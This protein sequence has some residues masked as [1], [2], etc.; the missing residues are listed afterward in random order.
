ML[1]HEREG[2]PKLYEQGFGCRRGM[3]LLSET[4]NH[5]NLPGN[6]R[7]AFGNVLVGETKVIVKDQA[8]RRPC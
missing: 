4:I 3:A 1:A 5:G 8:H 6:A 2:T 7:L